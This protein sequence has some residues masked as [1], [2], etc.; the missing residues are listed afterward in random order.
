MTA[1][2]FERFG[3]DMAEEVSFPK[4]RKFVLQNPDASLGVPQPLEY[5]NYDITPPLTYRI[6]KGQD[7]RWRWE[8]LQCGW[9]IK[10]C[11]KGIG[12]GNDLEAYQAL[13]EA[14]QSA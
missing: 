4:M 11:P 12:Y 2:K 13:K 14:V 10:E 1:I 6:A 5:T 3:E 9:P 8:I 7:E